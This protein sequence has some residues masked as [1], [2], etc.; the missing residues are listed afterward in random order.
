MKTTKDT[1]AM[2][3]VVICVL[4]VFVAFYG[5]IGYVAFHFLRKFW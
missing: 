1:L 5:S 3:G 2:I 4:T